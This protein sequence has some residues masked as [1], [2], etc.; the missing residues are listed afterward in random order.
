MS[1]VPPAGKPTTRCV[2]QVNPAH[3]PRGIGLRQSEVRNSWQRG[4]ARSQ[5]QKLS[6][7]KFHFEPPSRFTSLDH[8]V[9]EGE[10]RRGHVEAERPG[11]LEIDHRLV[12]GRRLQHAMTLNSWQPRFP[13][14]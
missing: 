7:G 14:Q 10:Q 3:R 2:A 8:L 9:G 6:A 1:V 4:S 5:M 12:F 11:G 13:R